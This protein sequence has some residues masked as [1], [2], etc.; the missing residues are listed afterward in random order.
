M[1]QFFIVAWALTMVQIPLKNYL[2]FTKILPAL[3]RVH[4]HADWKVWPVE[5]L[6]QVDEYISILEM[7]QSKP[8]YYYYL[9]TERLRGVLFIIVFVLFIVYVCICPF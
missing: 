9:K 8:W 5:E 1:I 2:L 7:T 4:G 6:A 3:R